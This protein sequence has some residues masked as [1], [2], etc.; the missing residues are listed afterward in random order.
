MIR[1]LGEIVAV[2]A[3]ATL[4]WRFAGGLRLFERPR[5]V[6]AFALVAAGLSAPI[7]ATAKLIS[8]TLAD[9]SDAV[10]GEAWLTSWAVALAI[11]VAGGPVLAAW[12][13]W[14]S[15]RRRENWQRRRRTRGAREWLPPRALE[16]AGLVA[17]SAVVGVWIARAPDSAAGA[18]NLWMLLLFPLLGWAALRL[19]PQE[20]AV[21]LT[22]VNGGVLWGVMHGRWRFDG[23]PAAI[24]VA[25]ATLSLTGLTAFMLAASI[26]YR[27]QHQTRLRQ[28]AVTDPLTGLAN[29]RHFADAVER[30]IGRARQRGEPFAVMLLDVD[31]LKAINDRDGHAAGSRMLI[32]LAAH[33]RECCRS[34]DLI[35]RHG[36]DE[37]GVVL[38]GCDAAAAD[39]QWQ[40]I[41]S[42]LANDTETPRISVSVG[43]SVF[44]GDGD[45]VETLLEKSD[46]ELYAAK[47]RRPAIRP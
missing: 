16:T 34:T 12:A 18:S 2:A 38:P 14:P 39:T 43:I 33:L 5:H 3:G 7:H 37:F 13:R 25:A 30:N 23:D 31:H 46:Q 41:Q 8:E 4:V 20:T 42:A 29:F 9:R 15:R 40:R 47:A 28:L 10:T 35:A 6:L 22:L 36:G 1:I 32:R 21:A 44:P 17:A 19:G 11:Y 27:S 26:E 24:A 45:T